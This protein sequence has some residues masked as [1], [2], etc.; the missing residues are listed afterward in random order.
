MQKVVIWSFM[1]LVGLAVG[2][3]VLF[4]LTARGGTWDGLLSIVQGRC[5][6]FASGT[7]QGM[8][9]GQ[10]ARSLA[11]SLVRIPAGYAIIDHDIHVPRG[12]MLRESVIRNGALRFDGGAVDAARRP[13]GSGPNTYEIAYI[14]EAGTRYIVAAFRE[15]DSNF[16]SRGQYCATQF[17]DASDSRLRTES[18]RSN[19]NRMW[20]AVGFDPML[21]GNIASG[22]LTAILL[23]GPLGVV[24]VLVL[25]VFMNATRRSGSRASGF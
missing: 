16:H 13:D 17:Q 4:A 10:P 15:G 24:G 23:M 12:T 18:T 11:D 19:G 1:L 2:S 22:L 3:A 21:S 5:T 6:Y 25:F 9:G 8:I 14:E 20:T 7:H